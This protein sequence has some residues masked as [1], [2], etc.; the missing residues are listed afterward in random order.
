M[1]VTL[2]YSTTLSP[3]VQHSS[4]E[5]VPWL[6]LCDSLLQLPLLPLASL[7]P[8]LT[9]SFLSPLPF[10]LSLSTLFP[11]SL[12]LLP[13]KNCATITSSGSTN[14]CS[15]I[16]SSFVCK[17]ISGY[18]VC[19]GELQGSWQTPSLWPGLLQPAGSRCCF[20]PPQ[21]SKCLSSPRESRQKCLWPLEL[22]VSCLNSLLLPLLMWESSNMAKVKSL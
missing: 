17:M 18:A 10:P 14:P 20:P 11:P 4:A 5:L 3:C 7:L 19:Q 9:A 15:A 6:W 8:T 12:P 1:C 21:E 13:G 22:V 2:L 16:Q